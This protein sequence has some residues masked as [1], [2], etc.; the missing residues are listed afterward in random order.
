VSV[1]TLAMFLFEEDV[2]ADLLVNFT[3]TFRHL[4]QGNLRWCFFSIEPGLL[5]M[6]GFWGPIPSPR[7]IA[8]F[9]P[10]SFEPGT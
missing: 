6:Q 4:R 1:K 9:I 10:R 2:L 3:L 7:S 8:A 5:P